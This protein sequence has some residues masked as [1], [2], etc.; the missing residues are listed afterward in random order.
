MWQPIE[1][2]PAGVDLEL[3][4]IDGDEIATV[5]FPC[6]RVDDGWVRAQTTKLIEV[7]PTHWRPWGA[8]E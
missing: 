4:V 5:A 6:R 1:S 8:D 3:A 7:N 2:A